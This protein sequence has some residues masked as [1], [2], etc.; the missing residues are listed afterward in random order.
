MSN[1]N[2]L[3]FTDAKPEKHKL[4]PLLS[5]ID[6]LWHELGDL[7]GVHSERLRHSQCSDLVKMSNILQSWLDKKPTLVT[8]RKIINMI[9]GPLQNKALADDIRQKVISSKQFYY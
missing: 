7:L 5:P 6:Y 8:W 2:T 3:Y 1:F 4:L 9:E